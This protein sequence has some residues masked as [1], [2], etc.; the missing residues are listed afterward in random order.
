MSPIKNGMRPIHPG[1]ILQKEF[2]EVIPMT[3][4]Q[5]AARLG[6]Q[7]ERIDRLV[8][9]GARVSADT[10]VRLGKCFGSS[11]EFWLNLQRAYDLALIR[12]HLEDIAK[13][14]N[15]FFVA[16]PEAELTQPG[17]AMVP[18]V[19]TQ[20]DPEDAPCPN[21]H[22][23]YRHARDC[24]QPEL[25]LALEQIAIEQGKTREAQ[26][27]LA[28]ATAFVFYEGLEARA[29][30]Q[31]EG[32]GWVLSGW[33]DVFGW[34]SLSRPETFERA[35]AAAKKVIGPVKLSDWRASP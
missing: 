8:S 3:H 32:D 13:D 4:F 18:D 1:E 19:A 33:A 27:L 20:T 2:L 17:S 15:P 22:W 21:C 25:T 30:I 9:G 26:A 5:L 6:V 35:L 11:P 16:K 31:K 23:R 24:Q 28:A 10:A 7:V 14:V 34:I 12:P 29:R